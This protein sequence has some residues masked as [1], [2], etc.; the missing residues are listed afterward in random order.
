MASIPAEYLHN[1]S[2][3]G[4]AGKRKSPGTRLKQSSYLIGRFCSPF[5][6]RAQGTLFTP[7]I[8]NNHCFQFL[9]GI[10]VDPREIEDNAWLYTPNFWG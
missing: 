1:P 6:H 9:L 3:S 4:R 8:L 7:E 5:S 10:P 2:D